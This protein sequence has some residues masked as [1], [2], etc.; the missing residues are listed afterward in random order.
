MAVQREFCQVDMPLVNMYLLTASL[1]SR[2]GSHL[3]GELAH[4]VYIEA[5][6][7]ADLVGQPSGYPVP[8][9]QKRS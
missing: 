5:L 8:G 3:L 2:F 4:H 1:V 9:G 6:I 7:D